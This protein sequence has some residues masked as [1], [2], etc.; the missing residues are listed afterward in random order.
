MNS[1]R[2]LSAHMHDHSSPHLHFIFFLWLWMDFFLP[3]GPPM[4]LTNK[5]GVGARVQRFS[6]TTQ[7]ASKILFQRMLRFKHNYAHIKVL[8]DLCTPAKILLPAI[9]VVW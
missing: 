7:P 1:L 9:N 4:G 2:R 5:T 6:A 3:T 8:A